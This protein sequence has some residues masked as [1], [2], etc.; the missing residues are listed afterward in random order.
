[1]LKLKN[2]RYIMLI[3]IKKSTR[4]CK[5]FLCYMGEFCISNTLPRFLLRSE[6]ELPDGEF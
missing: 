5:C 2:E 3:L 6:S 1:M 4:Y